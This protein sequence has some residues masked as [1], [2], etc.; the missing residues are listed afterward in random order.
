MNPD[1]VNFLINVFLYSLLAS[2]LFILI[3]Q[4]KS[5]VTGKNS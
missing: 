2:A 5:R 1:P 4:N 3:N